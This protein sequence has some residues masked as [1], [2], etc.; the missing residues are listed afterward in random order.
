MRAEKRAAPINMLMRN[1][2]ARSGFY[3]DLYG[4]SKSRSGRPRHQYVQ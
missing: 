1:T 2:A 3:P 4:G